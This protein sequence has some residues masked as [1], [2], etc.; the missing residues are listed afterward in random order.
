[1][2]LWMK[3]IWRCVTPMIAYIVVNLA[4]SFV[5]VSVLLTKEIQRYGMELYKDEALYNQVTTELLEKVNANTLLITALISGC[6]IPVLLWMYYR[7]H[8]RMPLRSVNVPVTWWA[9][10][11]VL[12]CAL[13]VALNGFVSLTPMAVYFEEGYQETAEAIYNSSIYLQIIAVAILAPVSEELIFRG[14]IYKRMRVFWNAPLATIA[15]AAVFGAFHGNMLQFIYATLL[16][17]ALAYVYE[18]FR[19]VLAPIMVHVAANA[20][21]VLISN[22]AGISNLIGET[23]ERML[24]AVLVCSLI[25]AI[26]FYI[27]NKQKE[28]GKKNETVDNC[29]AVL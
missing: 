5:V 25:S 6:L 14:L 22:H 18:R 28:E 7:D 20:M 17:C 8:K 3:R 11:I 16:G 21:S 15:S 29:G 19:T 9:V 12:G 27:M 10:I 13:C 4:V 24:V 2:D 1:M 23:K 26:C